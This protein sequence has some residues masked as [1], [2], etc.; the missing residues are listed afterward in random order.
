MRRKTFRKSL[1]KLGPPRK[2]KI[3]IG[4]LKL[5]LQETKYLRKYENETFLS[6]TTLVSTLESSLASLRYGEKFPNRNQYH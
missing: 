6:Y 4:F 5:L 1:L 2:M 3:I